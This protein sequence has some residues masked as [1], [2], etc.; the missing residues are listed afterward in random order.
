MTLAIV[1]AGDLL[2]LWVSLAVAAIVLG[3]VL[4]VTR[5]R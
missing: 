5:R 3:V 2:K 1:F 4:F